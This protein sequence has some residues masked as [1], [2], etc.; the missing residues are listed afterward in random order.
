MYSHLGATG[1]PVGVSVIGLSDG[2]ALGAA[3]LGP[4][5][6]LAAIAVLLPSQARKS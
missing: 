1:T 6:A 3:T 4:S 2:S 5:A